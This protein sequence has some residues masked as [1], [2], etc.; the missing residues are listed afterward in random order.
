MVSRII[1]IKGKVVIQNMELAKEAISEC[2]CDIKIDNNQFVFNEYDAF[3][4]ISEVQK[5]KDLEKVETLYTQKFNIYLEQTAEKERLRIEEEKRILR[6]AKAEL[7]IANAKKQGYKLKKEIRED[8]T[9]KLV[10]QKRV[11]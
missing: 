7:L 11:Y 5:M 8:N 3:D 9:I 6:E 2:D 10:I 4:R 1:N